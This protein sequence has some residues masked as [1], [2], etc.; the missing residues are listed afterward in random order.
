M[1]EIGG[2]FELK[3]I[4]SFYSPSNFFGLPDGGIL[5]SKMNLPLPID[6][7]YGVSDMD[8]ILAVLNEN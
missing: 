3:G 8:K 4:A 6:Q 7:R 2:Y 1:K 5:L